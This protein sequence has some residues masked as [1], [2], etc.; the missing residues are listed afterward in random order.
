MTT[1]LFFKTPKGEVRVSV[2]FENE[3]FWLTQ[4]A[5]AELFGHAAKHHLTFE[6]HV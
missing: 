2:R 3:T 4:K 1:I 6:K 5:M